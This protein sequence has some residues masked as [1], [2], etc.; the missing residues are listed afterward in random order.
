MKGLKSVWRVGWRVTLCAVLLAYAFQKIFVKLAASGMD[1]SKP[2]LEQWRII[3]TIG[4]RELWHTLC[5]VQPLALAGSLLCVLLTILLGVARWRLVLGVQGLQL[6]WRRAAGIT[7]VAQF[8]N[9]FLLGST[10]GDVIKALY[11]ARETHHKKTEAVI[12][13]FVDRLLGLW[14]MLFFA[15]LMMIPNTGLLRRRE[16][17]GMPALFI[18]LMLAGASGVLGVAFWSGLSKRFPRARQWLRKFPKGD[19]LERSLDSC[20][21]FGKSKGFLRRALVLSLLINVICVLQMAVLSAGL[22]AP[23]SFMAWLVIVPM[24]FCI[25]ALP[26]TPSGLGVRENLFVWMLAVP[27]I[28]LSGTTARVGA[29]ALSLSL[30]AYAGSLFWSLIGGLVYLGMKKAQHLEEVT[31]PETVAAVEQGEGDRVAAASR[32]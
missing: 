31:R 2:S 17:L 14:A 20:R 32:R 13:V 30:L 16:Q 8:F 1:A 10:G 9:A 5:L 27:E 15:A 21:H 6:P 19:Y 11:A 18:L 26:V 28:G 23:V 7:F 25:S 3:W 24:I 12:T 29:T 22:H 4:P